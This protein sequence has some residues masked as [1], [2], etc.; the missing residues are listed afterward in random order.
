MSVHAHDVAVE[1]LSVEDARA[2]FERACRTELGVSATEFLSAYRT[3]SLP[4]TWSEEAICRL[5]M[6]LPLAD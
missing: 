3:G 6:L 2:A 5:E 1:E 4:S